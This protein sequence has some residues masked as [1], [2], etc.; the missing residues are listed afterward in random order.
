MLIGSA[1]IRMQITISHIFYNQHCM[2]PL[3][4]LAWAQHPNNSVH[5]TLIDDSSPI[6]VKRISL[7]YYV[8]LYRVSDSINWNTPGARNLAFHVATTEWVLCADIDHIV[9]PFALS[10]I[11]E[12]DLSDP[13]T[14]YTFA[15]KRPDGF[16]GSRYPHNVLMNKQKYFDIGGNDEDFSGNYGSEDTF[17]GCCLD[18]HSIRV[19]HCR[20]IVLDWH[21]RLGATKELSRDKYINH[22]VF[23]RKIMSLN[24]KSY[25]NGSILRFKWNSVIV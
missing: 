23:A 25:V 24:N 19:T 14:V 3:H 15:R 11:L 16:F 9:T 10:S 6:P 1:I 13:N 7:P 18:Y 20:H 4:R 17:F 5:Y 2:L 8:D 22:T 12:L 21:P